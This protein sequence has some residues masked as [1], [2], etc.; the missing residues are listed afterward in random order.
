MDTEIKGTQEF[1]KY[2]QNLDIDWKE[3][4]ETPNGFNAIVY[5]PIDRSRFTQS[6]HSGFGEISVRLSF[7]DIYNSVIT[8]GFFEKSKLDQFRDEY[9][10]FITFTGDDIIDTEEVINLAI[11]QID[12]GSPKAGKQLIADW[13]AA[14]RTKRMSNK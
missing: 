13:K 11:V 1:K 2:L 8:K 14:L 5:G 3:I 7:K 10:D 4:T 12:N 9:Q 6:D